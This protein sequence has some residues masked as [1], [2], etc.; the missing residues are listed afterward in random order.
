M[1]TPYVFYQ[2]TVAPAERSLLRL[3]GLDKAYQEIAWRIGYY[4]GTIADIT[5][6]NIKVLIDVS[7]DDLVYAELPLLIRIT[8]ERTHSEYITSTSNWLNKIKLKFFEM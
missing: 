3:L 5:T 8:G 2:L 6:R 4:R 1:S 7:V